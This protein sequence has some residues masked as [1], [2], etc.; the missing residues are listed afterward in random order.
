MKEMK[1]TDEKIFDKYV[2][3]FN[4]KEYIPY[5]YIMVDVNKKKNVIQKIM[6]LM[7]KQQ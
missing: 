5:N 1:I 7:Q 2:K 4:Y 3:D 6:Y